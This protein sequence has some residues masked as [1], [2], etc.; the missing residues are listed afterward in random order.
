VARKEKGAT[1][2]MPEA[3]V[4]EVNVEAVAKVAAAAVVVVAAS[5]ATPA[6]ETAVAPKVCTPTQ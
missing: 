4:M 5:P 3:M 1:A 2:P 6:T